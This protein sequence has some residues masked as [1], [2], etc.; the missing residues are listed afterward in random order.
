MVLRDFIFYANR[1]FDICQCKAVC[2]I[3][4]KF[5]GDIRGYAAVWYG[6]F[7]LKSRSQN[8]FIRCGRDFVVKGFACICIPFG[9]RGFLAVGRLIALPKRKRK[10]SNWKNARYRKSKTMAV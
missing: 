1:R 9:C 7:S 6:I 8:M 2:E 10:I 5:D 4:V 3:I